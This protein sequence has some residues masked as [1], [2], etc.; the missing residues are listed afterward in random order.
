[1][2]RTD[3]TTIRKEVDNT[4]CDYRLTKKQ[5]AEEK[6]ALSKL[7][8]YQDC[9]IDAQ[10]IVQSIAQDIQQKAHNQIAGVVSRCLQTVFDDPY[11]FKIL[12][13]QKRGRTEAVLTFQ[14]DGL[15]ITDPRNGCGGGAV[16]VA[17]FALQLACLILKKPA[18]RKVM[19]LD[20]PFKGVHSVRYRNNVRK[21][22]EGLSKD[23]NIQ[24]IIVTQVPELKIG[25]V[26]E[27]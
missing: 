9:A 11:E 22:L 1:M 16:D 21:L 6:E 8:A 12:F 13:E 2:G 24:F 10:K 19:F 18:V 7:S 26:V 3:L 17:S 20:E 27:L 5:V 14:R 25:K 23:F 15:V 4:L